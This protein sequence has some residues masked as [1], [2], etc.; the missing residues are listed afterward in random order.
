MSKLPCS[1]NFTKTVLYVMSLCI[2]PNLRSRASS[3]HATKQNLHALLIFTCTFIYQVHTRL[4][5]NLQC[6]YIHACSFIQYTCFKSFWRTHCIRWYKVEYKWCEWDDRQTPIH[7]TYAQTAWQ[8]VND[9]YNTNGCVYGQ[10]LQ[11]HCKNT[12]T[13]LPADFMWGG[14][15]STYIIHISAHNILQQQNLYF[16]STV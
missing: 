13:Q 9:T 15:Y 10:M 11:T 12:F 16:N 4:L 6:N 3:S 2:S 8:P 14:W 1:S 5:C 7:L